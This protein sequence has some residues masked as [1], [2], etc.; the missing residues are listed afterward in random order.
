MSPVHIHLLL[1]HVP[2]LGGLLSLLLLVIGGL[3]KSRTTGRIALGLLVFSALVAI[4]VFLTGEPSEEV[5]E[6]LAGVSENLIEQHED[7]AKIAL[8]AIGASGLVGAL[9][10]VLLR[11]KQ[12]LPK[13]LMVSLIGILLV[14]NGLMIR[15]ANLGGQIRHSEIRSGNQGIVSPAGEAGEAG[16]EGEAHE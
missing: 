7:S 9:G 1:N 15:T 6:G 2:V 14:S 8:A 4:P 16:R 5:V 11:R 12:T 13:W 10:L 3:T